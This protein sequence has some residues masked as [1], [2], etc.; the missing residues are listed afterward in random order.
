MTAELLDGAAR[1]LAYGTA[2]GILI[3]VVDDLFIDARY[4]LG[5]LGSRRSRVVSEEALRNVA[6]RRVAIM[7]PA[8]R[9]ADV[10]ERMLDRN[11]GGIDYDQGRYDI[12]CGT[13]RNDP[14]TQARVDAAARRWGNVHKVVVPHDGP[15]SKAD[16]LNWVYQ[17]IVLHE[18]ER[19]LR[20][21]VL[22]MH[23]AEDVIH[24]L[25]LRLYSLLIPPNE[26]VQ[27]PVFSL[28]LPKR[29]CVSATYI[30]EFAEHHL[31]DMRVREAIGGLIPSAGVGSAF[32]RDAFEEIAAAHG[33]RPFNVD[34]LTE[35]YEIGLKFRLANR[36]THFACR[37]VERRDGGRV[38]EEFI[39]TR[40][41]FPDSFR[42]SVRQRS[43]WI[44]GITLQTWA[45]VGWRG[46]APVLYCLWRDRK[47]LF[48]NALLLAAYVLVA[49]TL[50]R[51]AAAHATG[52]SWSAGA[53]VPARSALWWIVVLNLAFAAWRGA[54]KARL[55]GRLY[56][57]G[58]ALLSA[59]RLVIANVIGILATLRAIGQY[60]AHRWT[61]RPLRWL[62]TAHD[63]PAPERLVLA[64]RRLGEYLLEQRA[65]SEADLDEAL[66]LH[67]ATGTRLGEVLLTAGVVSPRAVVEA[68]G[69][70]LDVETV[71][72]DPL[73]IA[74]P[75]LERLPEELAEE[76]DV[77]P[78]EQRG[79][80]VV[81]AVAEP[82]EECARRRLEAELGARVEERLS[83]SE[84]LRRAR[85]RAYRRLVRERGANAVA[86]IAE[87]PST[88]GDAALRAGADRAAVTRLGLGFCVFHC[89]V[90]LVTEEGSTP[91]VLSSAPLH[92]SVRGR[93]AR[94]LG[95][96][97]ELVTAA[98]AT[99]R[100]L[101][102]MVEGSIPCLV[103]D[104]GT[105]GLRVGGRGT[106][107]AA[108]LLPPSVALAHDVTI[109]GRDA[110]S[111]SLA[112]PRPTPA[113]AQ[114]VASLLSPLKV[115]W[116]VCRSD[117][118]DPTMPVTHEH[119]SSG[120][121]PA[122]DSPARSVA[123]VG[124]DEHASALLCRYLASRGWSVQTHAPRSALRLWGTQVHASILVLT[125][126]ED[127]AD[128][129]ELLAKAASRARGARVVACA[130]RS[131]ERALSTGEARALGVERVLG[132]RPRFSELAHA[133][134]EVARGAG[135]PLEA[136]PRS[137][138]GAVRNP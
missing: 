83:P 30:D 31:K 130:P 97:I 37:T 76:I 28:P 5:D 23:D 54:M 3:N 39:A 69:R 90:P 108:G 32:A 120:A 44:L 96:A 135:G 12:F 21:D 80:V 125:F 74:L 93:I 10:I 17:G 4:L 110:D 24:P 75:L 45:Q 77:L 40:E 53:I 84:S 119:R 101:L 9:E 116:S 48:T 13:Y 26:F 41:F 19:G 58:H 99:V 124:S 68:L 133:L 138:A 117:G 128:A 35:D 18:R 22:L 2:W 70:Q 81:V 112:A 60:A 95:A 113:L 71:E 103:G 11:V 114:R 127:D 50:A 42:A 52:G 82:L 6:Q 137:A 136:A 16:C 66:A 78:L 86:P 88:R 27:T 8:W 63:F 57:P 92:P 49:Y 131:F 14:E 104:A 105:F 91:R 107:S 61:G 122:S 67:R 98:P 59:P 62:K 109:V 25:A 47:A 87:P 85:E 102:A 29:S 123:L 79:G 1:V 51:A 106:R 65:L 36:R 46:T 43:R 34:S 89:V 115:A 132:P 126:E 111:V 134:E 94:R 73:T 100:L 33:Q 56:G 121:P 15:T 7:V 20:F 72:P 64:R 118:E 55:V 38:R 129:F